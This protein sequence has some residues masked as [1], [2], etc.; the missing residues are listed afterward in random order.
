MCHNCHTKLRVSH[1]RMSISGV[2]LLA[3]A[4]LGRVGGNGG[5]IVLPALTWTTYGRLTKA[6]HPIP[7][8]SPHEFQ[9]QNSVGA[10]CT[11]EGNR[12]ACMF[13]RKIGSENAS[14][15]S[16][17]FEKGNDDKTLK[18]GVLHFQTSLNQF[19]TDFP[20]FPCDVLC[21]TSVYPIVGFLHFLDPWQDQCH[22][23]SN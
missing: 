8:P 19:A 14:P 17:P 16:W 5:S 18:F 21:L 7:G 2:N 3:L 15:N 6:W 23:S 1:V 9:V 13:G 10:P 22:P 12:T 11:A 4:E 20:D